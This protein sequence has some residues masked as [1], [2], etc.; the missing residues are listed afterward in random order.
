MP[1]KPSVLMHACCGPCSTSCVERTAA[2]Y[3][4]T[5]Y[6][7]NPNI[8]DREEYYLRRDTLLHFL[9]AFNE[10]HKDMYTVGYIEGAYEPDRY[11]IKA[12]PLADEPEGGR[13]CDLCFAMRLA[14]TARMAKELGMEY[15]T[16]TMSVS[17]HKNYDKIK[18]LGLALEEETGVKFL[19]I[20]FKKKNGFGRSVELSKKYGLYRQNFCGCDFARYAA[21]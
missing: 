21:K 12:S 8:T 3:A 15:F 18:K 7:Y 5:L 9:E 16:T 11:I 10:E 1:K 17:P 13:R 4:L 20:D 14:E 2:D 19:D 6:Y